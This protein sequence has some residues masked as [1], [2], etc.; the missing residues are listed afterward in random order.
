[1][2]DEKFTQINEKMFLETLDECEVCYSTYDER[3]RRLFKRLKTQSTAYEQ[4]A[5]VA[6]AWKAHVSGLTTPPSENEKWEGFTLQ[7]KSLIP[8]TPETEADKL[9]RCIKRKEE[10]WLDF[11]IRFQLTARGA[12][13]ILM[14]EKTRILFCHLNSQLK[15]KLSDLAHN[16][17][18]DDM[19]ERIRRI[20][21]WLTIHQMSNQ[22]EGD[23]MDIDLA[24]QQT[25]P[26]EECN[27]YKLIE[28]NMVNFDAI[29]SMSTFMQ[30]VEY[31][32]KNRNNVKSRIDNMVYNKRRDNNRNR[33]QNKG[34]FNKRPYRPRINKIRENTMIPD[35]IQSLPETHVAEED[36]I[37]TYHIEKKEKKKNV[38][39]KLPVI[40]KGQGITRRIDG[41]VDTGAERTIMSYK[42]AKELEVDIKEDKSR[43]KVADGSN[44]IAKGRCQVELEAKRNKFSTDCLILNE[45][46]Y[47]L[48]LGLDFLTKYNVIVNPKQKCI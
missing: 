3:L 44:V 42:L 7:L 46:G 13:T 5:Q 17:T 10:T 25:E 21:Y 4:V 6:K 15:D 26:S 40:I 32:Y 27:T 14:N 22:Q 33:Y 38:I 11:V 37:Q 24:K 19:V 29:N 8:K 2:A 16:A 20:N 43:L 47:E 45:P 18:I 9:R 31:L 28:E 12:T 36:D 34:G 48:L 35:E 1:M 23:A 39:L 30:A 41:L